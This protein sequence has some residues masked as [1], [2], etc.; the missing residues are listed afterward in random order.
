MV[1]RLTFYMQPLLYQDDCLSVLPTLP[2][3]S[4]DLF[5]LDLPYGT[6]Q[7]QWDKIIPYD[8]LWEQINRL[9]K[10][11]TAIL[12]FAQSPFDKLLASSNIA[13]FK[14]EWIWEKPAATGFF[15]AKKM[16]LK[17][18]ENI[19]VFY[20]KP[21]TYN[22]QKTDGHARKVATKTKS[23]DNPCYGK[24]D[25]VVHYDSTERYPRSVIKFSSDKQSSSLHPT[26]KPLA[27][28]EYLVKTYS[29]E[30]DTVMDFCMGSGTTG[31]ACGNLG[32]KFIGI[33]KDEKYFLIAKNRL[34]DYL[35]S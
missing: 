2:D 9:R 25:K 27:L 16:P 17:A 33:E 6:T 1:L 30:G 18:H 7:N 15:N 11:N 21:P 10:P 8:S 22:P 26:Q 5:V 29:N 14:Y 4:V 24:A 20:E 28:V 3:S 23:Q 31:V 32:R 34:T 19:L 13:M 12:M 35:S